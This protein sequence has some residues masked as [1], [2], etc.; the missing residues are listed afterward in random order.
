PRTAVPSTR[1]N[2]A[3]STPAPGSRPSRRPPR[4]S[5]RRAGR[6]SVQP[7]GAGRSLSWRQ[8]KRDRSARSWSRHAVS[9]VPRAD[10]HLQP[11]RRTD[12]AVQRVPGDLPG[13]R[14]TGVA[15]PAGGPVGAARPA[16]ARR[17][18]GV[19]GG[20]A[21]ARLGCRAAR[22]PLRSPPAEELRAHAVLVLTR[23]PDSRGNGR[24]PGRWAAGG[25]GEA[26]T[27]LGLN[28]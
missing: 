22:R 28:Q 7:T 24:T 14:R 20:P 18:A 1:W 17:A 26:W 6:R 10:A 21:A 5:W 11:E 3:S 8:V 13:L 2:S 9:E 12:R 23:P 27:I 16:A 4:G 25:S 19:P 15:D